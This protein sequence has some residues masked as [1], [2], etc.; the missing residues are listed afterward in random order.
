MTETKTKGPK[1]KQNDR[2]KNLRIETKTKLPKQER[3]DQKRNNLT[4]NETTKTK[5]K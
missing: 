5:T 4:K 1:E 3:N 2:N